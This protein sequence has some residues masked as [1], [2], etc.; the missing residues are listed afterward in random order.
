MKLEYLPNAVDGAGLI[1]L[2]DYT[3]EDVLALRQIVDE[4]VTGSRE[5]IGLH[6]ETWIAPIG[7]C[8][9]DLHRG[10]RDLGVRQRAPL[11]FEC[12]LSADGWGNVKGLLEPFCEGATTG[13]QW[14]TH[15]GIVAFLIS[16]S[17]RW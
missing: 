7:G 8:R 15:R 3:Q 10:G 14:L 2:Y 6:C 12:E 5:R 16:H 4:L 13:F 17:G 1:R 9:L 11:S